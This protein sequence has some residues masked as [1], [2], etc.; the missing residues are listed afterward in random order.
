MTNVVRANLALLFNALRM[1]LSSNV[2]RLGKHLCQLVLWNKILHVMP[3]CTVIFKDGFHSAPVIT[4]L[5]EVSH[6]LFLVLLVCF[7]LSC[8]FG[9]SLHGSDWIYC[10]WCSCSSWR[11]F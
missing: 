5:L 2:T 10:I 1:F 4:G 11:G 3:S 9:E 8:L 6:T 7:S